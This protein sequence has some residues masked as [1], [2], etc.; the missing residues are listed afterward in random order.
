MKRLRTDIKDDIFQTQNL[1]KYYTN[2]Q[3]Y[4]EIYLKMKEMKAN[5]REYYEVIHQLRIIPINSVQIQEQFKE[6]A[7]EIQELTSKANA[8]LDDKVIINGMFSQQI[9]DR[10]QKNGIKSDTLDN[11]AKFFNTYKEIIN[12]SRKLNIKNYK[13]LNR[14]CQS[15]IGFVKNFEL[16]KIRQ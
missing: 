3:K 5:V 9:V 8:I 4:K 7:K 13:Q 10:Y 11:F 6:M 15:H 16:K 14:L 1:E 12:L 2:Y